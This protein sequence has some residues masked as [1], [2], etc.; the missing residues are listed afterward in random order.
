MMVKTAVLAFSDMKIDIK[1]GF[2]Q[3]NIGVI[4]KVTS[5]TYHL[6][7]LGLLFF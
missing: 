4:M 5:L 7:K 1:S 6:L 3:T 2:L